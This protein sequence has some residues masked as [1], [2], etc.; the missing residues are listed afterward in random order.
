MC[1]VHLETFMSL[2][3]STGRRGL[4]Q[5]ADDYVYRCMEATCS[6]Q[7]SE[8]GFCSRHMPRG[9]CSA[10]TCSQPA[11]VGTFCAVHAKYPKLL[12]VRKPCGQ[13]CTCGNH[14]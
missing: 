3:T 11:G 5:L 4:R 2:K 7:A 6:A 12:R 1:G 13:T 14:L 8:K 10:V 9:L